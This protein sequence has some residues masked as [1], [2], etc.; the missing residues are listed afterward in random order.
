MLVVESNSQAE[1]PLFLDGVQEIVRPVLIV[2]D[3][4]VSDASIRRV[5]LSGD[6]RVSGPAQPPGFV[7]GYYGDGGGD[8]YSALLQAL[9]RHLGLAGHGV[10]G[11]DGPQVVDR[12]L[13]LLRLYV[14]VQLVVL[15]GL[16]GQALAGQIAQLLRLPAVGQEHGRVTTPVQGLRRQAAAAANAL[17]TL[18][19]SIQLGLQDLQPAEGSKR[20]GSK[21]GGFHF[22]GKKRDT[23][24]QNR[25]C[26]ILRITPPRT[27]QIKYSDLDHKT[28]FTP[29]SFPRLSV[30]SSSS[31]GMFVS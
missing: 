31:L 8:T 28:P 21:L 15:L 19:Q 24:T 18:E 9:T 20:H 11:D 13:Q 23:E 26:F 25:C 4:P 6:D 29:M 10:G 17:L 1:V 7:P 22:R 2:Q 16:Q 3:L 5:H 14:Q 30:L 27:V 12:L